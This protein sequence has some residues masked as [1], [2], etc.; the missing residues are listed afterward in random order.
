MADDGRLR[1]LVLEV[2]VERAVLDHLEEQRGDVPRVEREA[3]AGIVAGR[4]SGAMIVTPLSVTT[5]SPALLS[6]TLPPSA[7]A[8][9]STMTEPGFMPSTASSVTSTGGL[10]PGTWA[11]V[12]TT[13]IAAMCA[14][15]LCCWAACSSGVSWRA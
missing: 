10:R 12:I 4:F 2:E 11:V 5:V 6:S 15:E 1:D 9:M 13:S 7:L 3:P 14:V 8:A